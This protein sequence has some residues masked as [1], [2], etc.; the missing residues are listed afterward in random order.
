[1][2]AGEQEDLALALQPPTGVVLSGR[3]RARPC[4]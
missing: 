4:R 1:M 3:R 2:T